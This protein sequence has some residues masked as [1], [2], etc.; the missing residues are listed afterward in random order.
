[1]TE[2]VHFSG[3]RMDCSIDGPGIKCHLLAIANLSIKN[4]MAT[5]LCFFSETFCD[6]LTMLL[7]KLCTFIVRWFLRKSVS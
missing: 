6:S 7:Q 2:I 1:M 3:E 5:P 4:Q